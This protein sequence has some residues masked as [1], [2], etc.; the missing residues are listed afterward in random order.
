MGTTNIAAGAIS[1]NHINSAAQL[2]V[3][4]IGLGGAPATS[5]DLGTKT[6]ALRLPLGTNAQRPSTPA[7]G[8]GTGRGIARE[9]ASLADAQRA[10]G[11]AWASSANDGLKRVHV[12]VGLGLTG[13]SWEHEK[14]KQLE[15]ENAGIKERLE[16]IEK[17][18]VQTK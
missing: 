17:T 16:Q 1:G 15:K 8:D 5:L 18:M 4:R 10:V 3:D 2:N 12:A 7:N 9:A 11:T 13:G 14:I 6:D